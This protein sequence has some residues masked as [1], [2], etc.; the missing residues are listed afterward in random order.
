M[1]KKKK[2]ILITV[3][4]IILIT[5]TA[6]SVNGVLNIP[7]TDEESVRKANLE[8]TQEAL[9]KKEQF[10]KDGRNIASVENYVEEDFS[11]EELQRIEAQKHEMEVKE[12][13]IKDIMNRYYPEEFDKAVQAVEND[14]KGITSMQ[15]DKLSDSQIRLYDLV[16]KVLEEENLNDED[17]N[18][19]KTFIIDTKWEISKDESLNARAEKILSE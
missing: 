11:E 2:I 15:N 9:E 19:L 14:N 18:V 7:K 1:T 5:I 17:A 16:L 3:F 12:Q 10:A 6:I 13:R 4:I 8:A